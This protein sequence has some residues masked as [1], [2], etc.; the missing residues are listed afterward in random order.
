MVG[1]ALGNKAGIARQP[2]TRVSL[3]DLAAVGAHP[4]SMT[5]G[6]PH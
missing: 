1:G 3:G 5:E 2:L 6:E 4:P